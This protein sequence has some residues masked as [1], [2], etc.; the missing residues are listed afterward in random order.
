MSKK[1][2]WLAVGVMIVGASSAGWVVAQE[3]RMMPYLPQKY[4]EPYTPTL[5]EWHA[6]KLMAQLNTGSRYLSGPLVVEWCVVA[7]PLQHPEE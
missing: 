7:N 6:L 5:A 4:S 2:L 1:W 3:E